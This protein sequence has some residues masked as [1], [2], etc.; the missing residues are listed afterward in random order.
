METIETA[1]RTIMTT[2]LEMSRLC[3]ALGNDPWQLISNTAYEANL[4]PSVTV[5]ITLFNYSDYI[6]ECLDSVCASLAEN[7]PNGFDVLVIDDCSTD[8][9]AQLVETYI[10][11]VSTPICLVKKQFNTGLGDARNVGLKLA[12]APFIFVLDADNWI[13]PNCL[14]VLYTTIISSDYAAVYGIINRFN[15][16]T[17]KGIGLM[18]F[19]EWDVRELISYPYIDAMAMFKKEIV[20][21]VGGYSTELMCIA[22]SGWED[23]DLWLKLAQ[24]K[25]TCKLIP[26]ILSSYRVHPTSMISTTNNHSRTIAQHF[27]KKFSL[28]LEQHSDL[29]QAFGYPR[30]SLSEPAPNPLAEQ[31]NQ[32]QDKLKRSQ[33]R[34]QDLE[35]ELSDAKGRIEAMETSK[36]WHLRSH[37]FKFKRLIRLPMHE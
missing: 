8:H 1:K 7:L 6:Q 31:L 26:R 18:S 20:I 23:Y 37:W 24:A 17:R 3:Q 13:Y 19:Y 16:K 32:A 36:F 15:H 34:I 11:K 22:W 9:S 10:Q 4:N 30:H 35:R 2:R 12:R 27:T 5:L 28:L 33:K 29:Q 25:Q 21:Q 14:S